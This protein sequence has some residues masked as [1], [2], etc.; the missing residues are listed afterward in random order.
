M[1]ED[2]IVIMHIRIIRVRI[3]VYNGNWICDNNVYWKPISKIKFKLIT[4][5]IE[6]TEIESRCLHP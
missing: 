1:H 5:L 2:Y 4:N 6:A 3:L